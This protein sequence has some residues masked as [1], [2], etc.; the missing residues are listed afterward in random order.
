MR[1]LIAE[2]PTRC[3][4]E[5][6]RSLDRRWTVAGPSQCQRPLNDWAARKHGLS[7]FKALQSRL[8]RHTLCADLQHYLP[9][10]SGNHGPET[11]WLTLFS[12]KTDCFWVPEK[13]LCFLFR[14]RTL[15][16]K[17]SIIEVLIDR[18]PSDILRLKKW[19]LATKAL[20]DKLLTSSS[21]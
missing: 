16:K 14:H 5:L 15:M 11:A 1:T 8:C 13:S 2:A 19:K 6:N 4:S 3:R 21:N 9:L 17:P 12:G 20:A 10:A 18:P 7:A